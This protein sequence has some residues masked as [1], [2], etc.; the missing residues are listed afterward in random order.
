MDINLH[1]SK[2]ILGNFIHFSKVF[3]PDFLHFSKILLPKFYPIRI[4][5]FGNVNYTRMRYANLY[6]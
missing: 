5:F 3:L 4:I 2:A 1:F 6:N